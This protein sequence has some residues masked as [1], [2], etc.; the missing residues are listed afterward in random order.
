MAQHMA[1]HTATGRPVP[2]MPD[3]EGAWGIYEPFAT[4]DG[5]QVFV[6]ITSDNHW[7][8]FCDHFQRPD[9][10][11]DPRYGS[12]EERVRERP[13]LI[14]I[15]A[16]LCRRHT[17]A[18]LLEILERID[19]PCA[20]VATAEDRFDDPHLNANGRLLDVELSGGLHT[21]LPRLPLELGGHD[22]GLRRQ[23]PGIG[24]HTREVLVELGLSEAE[25]SDLEA[26]G[27]VR[28]AP[29]PAPA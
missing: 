21:R 24:Q 14:P 4:A 12:N 22:L 28:A 5:P 18:E 15:V 16:A 10:R 20:P 1:G 9:L 2:P 7:R 11:D 29:R 25:L 13:T 3:R 26:R 19:V 6:G 23:P 27:I 17:Q 8:R